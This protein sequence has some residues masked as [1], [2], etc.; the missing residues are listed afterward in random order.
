M[1]KSHLQYKSIDEYH[2]CFD[3]AIQ[4]KLQELR[5]A[6]QKAAPQATEASV[7]LYLHLN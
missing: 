3:A 1:N 2:Q 6:I 4:K 7:M 5:M